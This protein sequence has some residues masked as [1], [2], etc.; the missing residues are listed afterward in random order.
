MECCQWQSQRTKEN[1]HNLLETEKAGYNTIYVRYTSDSVKMSHTHCK[2]IDQ[3]AACLSPDLGILSDFHHP[4]F[5]SKFSTRSV[6][7]LQERAALPSHKHHQKQVFQKRS[8]VNRKHWG[9][10]QSP[11]PWRLFFQKR[12]D[13][14]SV[15]SQDESRVPPV[16]CLC[17]ALWGFLW[18]WRCL[19]RR[20]ILLWKEG[21]R[22]ERVR[23]AF[24]WEETL[25]V[26]MKGT[27]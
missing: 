13:F 5:F 14:L 17:R 16:C 20:C 23:P 19:S 18:V 25:K 1:H 2:E 9:S 22:M 6:I 8:N 24:P 15:F 3:Q 10:Y 27:I 11:P 21:G 7:T 4:L 12:P 26:A